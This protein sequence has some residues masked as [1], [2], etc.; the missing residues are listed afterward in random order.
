MS[1]LKDIS[2]KL[3][4]LALNHI[5][6]YTIGR[7]RNMHATLTTFGLKVTSWTLPILRNVER[8]DSIYNNSLL[9]IQFGGAVGNLDN[10]S[11]C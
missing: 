11:Y 2:N 3:L 8:L 10:R 5:D 9:S 1:N 4:S 6:T 7:T